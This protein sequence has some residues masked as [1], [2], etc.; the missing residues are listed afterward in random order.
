MPTN[1][2]VMA[3]H[4]GGK[5][6]M[7]TGAGKNTVLA[8]GELFVEYP[9]AG[10]GKG[11][12]K[13]KIGDGVTAYSSLPYALGETSTDLITFSESTATTVTQALNEAVSGASLATII[14]GL[15]KAIRLASQSGGI[16][17]FTGTL[18]EWN[19]LTDAEKAEYDLISNDEPGGL[20]EMFPS[21]LVGYGANSN[22][23]AE[24]NKLN[25]DWSNLQL[26]V[27]LQNFTSN[28][29]TINAGAEGG[30]TI[31]DVY[32]TGYDIA[33]ILV[34]GTGS[35]KALVRSFTFQTDR[36]LYVNVDNFGPSAVTVTVTIGV[37]FVR[38]VKS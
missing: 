27:V 22:V 23:E 19:Q 34:V 16:N 31:T 17:I 26:Q 32:K 12:S 15:K 36:K 2:N 33:S 35:A 25:D 14:G 11:K 37:F 13:I 6:K 7:T 10:V 24:L 21:S 3:P 38:L 5:T 18:A 8:D 29:F 1:L 30:V 20:Q 28:S 9:D 4:R